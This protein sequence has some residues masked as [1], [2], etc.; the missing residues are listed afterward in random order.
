MQSPPPNV[1][2]TFS[3]S[4]DLLTKNGII[5]VPGIVIGIV[6]GIIDYFLIPH[7]EYVAAY[8]VSWWSGASAGLLLVLVNVAGFILSQCYMTGM[9]G[10]AWQ[11]GSTVLRDGTQAFE[12]DASNTLIALVGLVIAF[13]IAGILAF[14]TLGISVLLYFYFFLYT[15]PAA[16]IGERPGFAAMGDSF[17]I[18]ARRVAPTLI[19]TVMIAVILFVC[20]FVAALLSFVPLIGPIVAAIVVQLVLAYVTLVVVGEYLALRDSLVKPPTAV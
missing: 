14:P 9:A 1:E 15:F 8:N 7:S 5:I 18:A 11:R 2:S 3:R 10:A 17:R 13:V 20:H 12:R 6:L 19:V 4:W 16:I